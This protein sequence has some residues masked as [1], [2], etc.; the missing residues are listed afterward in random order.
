MNLISC[1][2]SCKYQNEGYC[3]LSDTENAKHCGNERCIYFEPQEES[4]EFPFNSSN[5]SEPL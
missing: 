4:S 3:F 1:N 5:D 2:F